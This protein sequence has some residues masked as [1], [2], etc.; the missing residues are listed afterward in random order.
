[1]LV[2]SHVTDLRAS[3]PPDNLLSGRHC[4]ALANVDVSYGIIIFYQLRV[5]YNSTYIE[6]HHSGAET[7]FDAKYSVCSF[8]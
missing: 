3:L 5:L 6:C 2:F 8:L 4:C 7:F 1:M